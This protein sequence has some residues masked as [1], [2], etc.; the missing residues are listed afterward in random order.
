MQLRKRECSLG[1]KPDG[2]SA[3]SKATGSKSHLH[4]SGDLAVLL[5]MARGAEAGRDALCAADGDA[6]PA[7]SPQL[8]ARRA[9]C[10]RLPTPPVLHV[11]VI[12][13]S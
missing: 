1:I 2:L 4:R 13:Y 8:H 11:G 3:G 7:P 12:N 9:A 6:R 10:L 5:R